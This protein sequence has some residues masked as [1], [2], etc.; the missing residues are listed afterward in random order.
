MEPTLRRQAAALWTI[1]LSAMIAVVAPWLC[2]GVPECVEQLGH[3][4]RGFLPAAAIRH[5][6]N[7]GGCVHT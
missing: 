2:S 5:R 1:S 3:A 7:L 6:T 4:D